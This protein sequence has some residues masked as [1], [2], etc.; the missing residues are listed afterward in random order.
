MA[1]T[2]T[3]RGRRPETAC[4]TSAADPA[5]TPAPTPGHRPWAASARAPGAHR[6][7][8]GPHTHVA[9]PPSQTEIHR[10]LAARRR[11]A[12]LA[13]EA[14]LPRLAPGLLPEAVPGDEVHLVVDLFVSLELLAP[15][16]GLPGTAAPGRPPPGRAR[17]RGGAARRSRGP[18]PRR[19][20]SSGG[21]Y[22]ASR[23]SAIDDAS[24]PER[25]TASRLPGAIVG[26]RA[27][28]IA[29]A[30]P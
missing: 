16:R 25:T 10:R 23:R 2:P 18:A 17:F 12:P 21:W 30:A 27:T 8:E 5:P 7:T 4:R 19:R 15:E 6:T 26:L 28:T 22:V 1:A 9:Y 13:G 24:M 11:S 14:L 29:F 3:P 20:A